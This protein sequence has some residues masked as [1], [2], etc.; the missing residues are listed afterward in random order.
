[1][2]GLPRV[3]DNVILHKGWFSEFLPTW[4]N[5]YRGPILFLHIDADLYSSTKTVLDLLADRMTPGTII[6]FDEYFNFPNWKHNGE[7]RAFQEF[8]EKYK[9]EYDYIGYTKGDGMQV[10]VKIKAISSLDSD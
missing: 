4:I 5:K 7:F 9:V 1:M 6:Q 10:A 3:R 8:V 2:N